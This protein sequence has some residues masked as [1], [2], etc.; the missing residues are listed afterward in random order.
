M[1]AD[2]M[3]VG[4]IGSACSD[5]TVGGIAQITAAGLSTVSPSNTRPALTAE[6][7]GPDYAGYLRT[8]HNDL[9]QG[10]VVADFVYNEL[11]LRK[12]ATIHDGS[13]YGEALQQVF[14]DNFTQMGGEVLVR[15]AVARDQTDMKPVLTSIAATGPEVIYYPIFVA[16]GAYITAQSKEVAG[17]ENVALIGS[18][19]MFTADFV[20][21]AGPAAAGMYL[22][23]PAVAG[24]AYQE[25]LAKYV[26]I[27]GTQPP[28]PF[29]AHGYDAMNIMLNAIEK[30]AVQGE[31]GTLYVPKG[32]L[33]EA[34]YAT[35]GWP[36][37][38][39]TITCKPTGDCGAG[40]IGIYQI[41]QAEVDGS[42]PPA[43]IWQPGAAE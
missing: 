38:T 3:A 22:S 26:E 19:G 11:G 7:R 6:D 12:A 2:P 29:H 36:G 43:L 40:A 41:T 31:D 21:A 13:S 28:A 34:L 25:F 18:D 9:V 5:E 33:R 17:L 15:E 27:N 37:L 4:L 8:A 24:E 39:G 42:W 20:K 32:A 10:A 23:S 16:A 14:A 1:S 30:V 35:E